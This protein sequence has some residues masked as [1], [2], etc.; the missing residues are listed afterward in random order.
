MEWL[1]FRVCLGACTGGENLFDSLCTSHPLK[2]SFPILWPASSV[3]PYN[4]IIH[5]MRMDVKKKIHTM[6]IKSKNSSAFP[7]TDKLGSK[8]ICNIP[9]DFY[10]S[11]LISMI[12]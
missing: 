6:R 2:A 3:P 8:N 11:I 12:T 9:E 5:T 1:P 4:Y 10:S 7:Y